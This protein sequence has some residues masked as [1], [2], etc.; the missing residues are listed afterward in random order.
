MSSVLVTGGCGFIGRHLVMELRAR[1]ERVRILDVAPWANLPNGVEFICGS[2]LDADILRKAMA[3]TSEVYHLAAVANLWVRRKSDLETIN[4]HGTKLVL[5]QAREHQIKRVVHCS[6]AAILLPK[7]RKPDT[8]IDEG[9]RLDDRELPGP[10]TRSKQHAEQ[11]A[12][13]AVRQGLDVVI[14]NPTLPIGASDRNLTPPSAMIYRFVNGSS[15]TFLDCVFNLVDVRDVAVGMVHAAQR[16]RSGERY[17]LGGE[18]IHL[19]ELLKLLEDL[20]GRRMPR[21]T[22]PTPVA[23]MAATI[24]EGI[25]DRVT[26]TPPAATREGVR[27]AL[28]S[29]SFDSGKARRE[30]GF[31]PRPIREALRN[32]VRWMIG[33]KQRDPEPKIGPARVPPRL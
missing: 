25:A 9:V 20:S 29:A 15:P 14:V 18:N 31:A 23:M 27:L 5:E 1:G 33:V 6:S 8:P 11:V 7:I 19:S 2:I 10:Y 26:G 4:A 28:R 17:I 16:G 22:I 21:H 30:L 24:L 3:Q 12:M 13:A 32:A